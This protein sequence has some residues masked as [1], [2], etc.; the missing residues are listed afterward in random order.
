MALAVKFES[1]RA[2][3]LLKLLLCER[4]G[5]RGVAQDLPMIEAFLRLLVGRNIADQNGAAGPGDALHLAERN[6]GLKKVMEREA[7][8]DA[9]K[10]FSGEGEMGRGSKLPGHIGGVL[11]GLKAARTFKHGRHHIQSGDV[12]RAFREEAGDDAGSA[13]HVKHGVVGAY[14]SAIGHGREQIVVG[15]GMA[16]NERVGLARELV[17]NLGFVYLG[18]GALSIHKEIMTCAG[19]CM[20]RSAAQEPAVESQ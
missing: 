9:V 11:L 15:V 19:R 20:V 13:G 14:G 12:A 17:Q 10:C 5:M 16:A 6:C 7:R 1:S 3:Q 4:A 8:D 2:A 18:F